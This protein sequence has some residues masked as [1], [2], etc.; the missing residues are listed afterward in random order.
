M[1]ARGMQPS[2]TVLEQQLIF[3]SG[4]ILQHLR[5]EPKEK[6]FNLR[7]LRLANGI[8]IAIE[9]SYTPIKHF[10]GMELIDFSK[11]SL[12]SILLNRYQCPIGW[13]EDIIEASK[14][15][16]EEARLLT[17]PRGFGILSI[18]RVVMSTEGQPIEICRS[19]YRS[20]RYR[21]MIR[22]PR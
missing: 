4:D 1:L 9:D 20:D 22:I 2:S 12:Y 7:R 6:V 17:I 5:L 10:P 16:A 8:P 14:A 19:R 21:A 13:S 18:S 15:T 3:P 11:E